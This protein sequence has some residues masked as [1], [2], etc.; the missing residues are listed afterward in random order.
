MAISFTG[1]SGAISYEGI[2]LLSGDGTST[3]WQEPWIDQYET[4]AFGWDGEGFTASLMGLLPNL[5]WAWATARF[6]PTGDML[7]EPVMLGQTATDY[8]EYDAETDPESGTT[9]FVG[10]SSLG[11]VLTGLYNRETSLTAPSPYWLI[12]R[13]DRNHWAGTPA[14]AL[15][16]S[17]ALV[18]WSDLDKG[19][20]A[21]E[22]ALPSG[23]AGATWFIPTDPNNIFKRVVATRAGDRW[24]VVGQ[25]Y[26]GLVLAEIDSKGMRQ[27]RLLTHAP[28]ACAATDSCPVI[29]DWRWQIENMAVAA[30]GDSAWVGLTDLSYER[31]ENDL[32]LF[33]YRI[34]P[35]RD[36]CTYQS[37]ASR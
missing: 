9:V 21:R 10:A 24:I 14:V 37:L 1:I 27:R 26:R 19:M 23:Q 7:A 4:V 29:S 28:A 34:L 17:T 35:L 2:L 32:T 25:D 18:A 31:V 20:V 6:T 36:G 15:N 22:V 8:G 13:D 3:I 5:A 12:N 30:Y 33:T 11:T 16:G